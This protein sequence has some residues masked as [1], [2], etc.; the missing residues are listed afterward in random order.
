MSAVGRF[1]AAWDVVLEMT[2]MAHRQY[3]CGGLSRLASALLSGVQVG[4]NRVCERN[5]AATT[6]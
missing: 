3:C 2:G 4:L 5:A 6:T 1:L